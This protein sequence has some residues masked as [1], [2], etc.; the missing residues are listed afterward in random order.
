MA[1]FEMELPTDIIKRFEA[2]AEET[3]RIMGEMTKAGAAVVAKNMEGSAPDVIKGH[4]KISKVYKT[5]SDGGINTKVYV[6]GYIPF[7]D[8]N[9]QF[10]T[11]KGGNGK[12]YSTNKGVPAEFLA[13]LYE[14][15]RH[16]GNPFPKHPFMRK[17]FKSDQIEG[18][19]EKVRV[20][21]YKDLWGEKDYVENWISSG[22]GG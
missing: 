8:P 18:A 9:R 2:T 21:F 20:K 3:E 12:Q 4:I 11:R 17:S 10:F 1:K 6:S 16:D 7:S 15:G 22:Y 5:P 13:N 14:Y 19:M